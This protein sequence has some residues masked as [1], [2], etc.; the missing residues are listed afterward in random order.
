MTEKI[1]PI[2]P[3]YFT[4]AKIHPTI[5]LHFSS[6]KCQ[7]WL[8]TGYSFRSVF[9]P[10]DTVIALLRHAVTGLHLLPGHLN[11][12]PYMEAHIHTDTS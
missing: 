4:L 1:S 2:Q 11:I 12:T 3:K 10:A 8:Y 5:F 9:G 6:L 7:F